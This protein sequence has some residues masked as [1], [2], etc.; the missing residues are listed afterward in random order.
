MS[1]DQNFISNLQEG[2][3]GEEKR[4]GGRE[5]QREVQRLI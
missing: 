5:T 2:N 3:G 4:G 1:M